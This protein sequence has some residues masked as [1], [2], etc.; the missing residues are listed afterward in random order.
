MIGPVGVSQND[1]QFQRTQEQGGSGQ[2]PAGLTQ[3][4]TTPPPSLNS[5]LPLGHERHQRW[6][7]PLDSTIRN[8]TVS[9]DYPKLAPDPSMMEL[10]AAVK[11]V[12]PSPK[13]PQNNVSVLRAGTCCSWI[14]VNFTIVSLIRRC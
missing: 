12:T 8:A 10:E 7:R 3:S 14:L 1:A 5:G 2:G 6:P 9:M 11:G 13:A 4:N